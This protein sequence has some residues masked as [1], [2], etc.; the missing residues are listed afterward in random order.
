M[1]FNTYNHTRTCLDKKSRSKKYQIC[2]LSIS[3]KATLY[4]GA[5]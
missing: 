2:S 5:F 1:L 4:C 3:L